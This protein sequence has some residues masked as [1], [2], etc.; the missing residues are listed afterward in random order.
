MVL[1][2]EYEAPLNEALGHFRLHS[3]VGPRL[4]AWLDHLEA[5]NYNMGILSEAEEEPFF[6]TLEQL[7]REALDAIE[8]VSP[9]FGAGFDDSRLRHLHAQRRD[10]LNFQM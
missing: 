8:S 4:Q 1:A 2:V 10:V 6:V 5:V 9:P 7:G 3:L